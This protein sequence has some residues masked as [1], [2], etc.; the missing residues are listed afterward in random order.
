MT[1]ECLPNFTSSLVVKGG[2]I[3]DDTLHAVFFAE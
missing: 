2:W 3:A 1:M